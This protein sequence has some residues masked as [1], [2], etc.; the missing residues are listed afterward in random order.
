MKKACYILLSVT[1]IFLSVMVGVFIGRNSSDRTFSVSAEGPVE[2]FRF[3]EAGT[4][5]PININT[6]TIEEL[7]LLPGI[8]EST[9]QAITDYRQEHGDFRTVDDLINVSG[10]GPST[11]NKLKYLITAGE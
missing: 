6:A 9:A 10:I 11:L 3:E 4:L 8:G 5:R 2:T 1:A 7:C